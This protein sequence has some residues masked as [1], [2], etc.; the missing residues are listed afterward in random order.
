MPELFH[1]RTFSPRASLAAFLAFAVFLPT[2]AMAL[3]EVTG[4]NTVKRNDK[5][6]SQQEWGNP[7]VL[8]RAGHITRVMDGRYGFSIIDASG[9][10]IADFLTPQEAIGFKLAAGEY[11]VE[12]ALCRIH[13]HHH[14]EV[15]VTED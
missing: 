1:L 14:V 3:T 13:R 8:T 15:T 11:K 10:K 4:V 6:N 2:S 9:T 5:F 7:L 12:P